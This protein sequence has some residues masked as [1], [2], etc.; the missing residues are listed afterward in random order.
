[1]IPMRNQDSWFTLDSAPRDGTVVDLWNFH[2]GTIVKGIRW[3]SS[4]ERDPA[5]YGLGKHWHHLG[6]TGWYSKDMLPNDAGTIYLGTHFSHWRYPPMDTGP[7]V[8]QM[9]RFFMVLKLK[10][11]IPS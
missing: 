1:M 11:E 10:D 6:Q 7:T 9:N 5:N 3:G 4:A 8:E 2:R